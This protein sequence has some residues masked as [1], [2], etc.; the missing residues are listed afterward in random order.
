[1]YV[2]SWCD[3]MDWSDCVWLRKRCSIS[4]MYVLTMIWKPSACW[5]L[6]FF[7]LSAELQ[8]LKH[9]NIPSTLTYY[10]CKPSASFWIGCSARHSFADVITKILLLN[11][12]ADHMWSW[13]ESGGKELSAMS[14]VPLSVD[15]KWAKKAP[16]FCFCFSRLDELSWV[17]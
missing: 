8:C 16:W 15:A 17:V 5:S 9:V 1:M 6:L 11:P 7:F 13:E 4:L 12:T 2:C 3:F 14:R 10:N